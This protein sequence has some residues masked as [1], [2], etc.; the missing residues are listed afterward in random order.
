[1]GKGEQTGAQE[2]LMLQLGPGADNL[3]NLTSVQGLHVWLG[4]SSLPPYLTSVQGLHV[5]L[6]CSSSLAPVPGHPREGG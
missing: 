4:C 5:W 6:G 3:L 1:M 2:V